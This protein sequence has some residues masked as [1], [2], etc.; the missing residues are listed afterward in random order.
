LAEGF[1]DQCERFGLPT[2]IS[3]YNRGSRGRQLELF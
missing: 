3:S 2:R 1:F